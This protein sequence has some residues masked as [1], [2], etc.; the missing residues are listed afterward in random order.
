M[1]H[2]SIFFL[3]EEQQMKKE[4]KLLF[5]V[6]K[7]DCNWD[8]Y[9]CPGPGGQH[10]NKVNTGVRCTHKA[11]G[12]VGQSCEERSQVQ[13][14]KLAFKRMAETDVFKV[15]HRMEVAR[16]TGLM[17][18]IEREVERQMRN[19]KVEIKQDGLWTEINK[20]APLPDM[21]EGTD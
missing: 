19:I 13:N 14:K 16:K 20:D 6:T 9:R 7:E 21:S 8:Y 1:F 15:W 10:V 4:R 17:D 12:A 5:S 11:S 18:Q 3:C 2:C